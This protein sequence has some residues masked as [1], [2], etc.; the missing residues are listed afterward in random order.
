MN[1]SFYYLNKRPNYLNRSHYRRRR[2]YYFPN[3]HPNSNLPNCLKLSPTL[4]NKSNLSPY[5]PSK[6]SY[7]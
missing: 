5:S 1:R 4:L 3:F 7:K 6:K 2:H